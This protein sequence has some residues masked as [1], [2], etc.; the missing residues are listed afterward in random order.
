MNNYTSDSSDGE[1]GNKTIDL[2]YLLKSPESVDKLLAP[3][4]ED[5]SKKFLEIESMILHH[6]ELTVVPSSLTR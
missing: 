3:Y 2:A 4:F 5:G 6:N 1:T